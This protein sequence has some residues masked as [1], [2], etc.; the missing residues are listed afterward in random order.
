MS[1]CVR[2]NGEES[3]AVDPSDTHTH[4]DAASFRLWA[5]HGGNSAVYERLKVVG[6]CIVWYGGSMLNNIMGKA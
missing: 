1:V 5:F 2:D 4:T 6:L 3:V